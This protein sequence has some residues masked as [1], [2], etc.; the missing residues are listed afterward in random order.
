MQ[1]TDIRLRLPTL[2]SPHHKKYTTT[3]PRLAAFAVLCLTVFALLALSTVKAQSRLAD[4]SLGAIADY[5]TETGQLY[6]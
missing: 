3:Y 1:S 2:S 5:Y 6:A 4:V